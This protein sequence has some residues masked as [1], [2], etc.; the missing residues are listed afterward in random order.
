MI[1][2]IG[3]WTLLFLAI[4]TAIYALFWDRPG[5]RSRP[6]LRCRK[7]WYDLTESPGDLKASPIQCPECGKKHPTR[8]AMRKIR[9]S[10]KWILAA[11]VLWGV[12][13]GASVT[14]RVQSRGLGAAIP[15]AFIVASLPFLSEEQGTSES[16][17]T[18]W[19][20]PGVPKTSTK[21]DQIIYKEVPRFGYFP[22]TQTKKSEFGWFSR[23][24]AF[25]LARL[26]SKDILTDGTTAKGSAYQGILTTF[27]NANQAY[28]FESDWAK[29]IITIDIQ[30]DRP[31]GPQEPIYGILRVRRML[32]GS[33]RLS[34]GP[35]S[36]VYNCSTSRGMRGNGMVPAFDTVQ[37]R[38]EF[39]IKRFLWDSMNL[40]DM[41]YG[42]SSPS[43]QHP[44]GT[45][46]VTTN[47]T[48]ALDL[49]IRVAKYTG[50]KPNGYKDDTNWTYDFTHNESVNYE[51]D[52]ARTI[53]ADS[54]KTLREEIEN[55]TTANLTVE[56]D[57]GKERWIPVLKITI[58]NSN[59]PPADQD[60]VLFGGRIE[61]LEVPRNDP[62]T[63]GTQYFS[64]IWDSW[65]QWG[66]VPYTQTVLQPTGSQ[67]N[68]FKQ[69]TKTSAKM[70]FTASAGNAVA[71]PGE[72][73]FNSYPIYRTPMKDSILVVRLQYTRYPTN[74]AGFGGLWA[75]RVYEGTIQYP[76][77]DW[78]LKELR[79]YIV[80]GTVPDH[81]MP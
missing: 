61:I 19:M 32:A 60:T 43:Q 51:I 15:R 2:T 45:G 69:T 63:H 18:F 46:Q 39:W 70:R 17:G 1:W 26:E 80:N 13:Y 62:T 41:T 72:L 55:S 7:C 35:N 40:K 54:S 47:D 48:G 71:L 50:E 49:H 14:P 73:R 52:Q 30:I 59:K 81:S 74:N 24:I 37:E 9:R 44:L 76:L 28:K 4:A 16:M 21:F 38:R 3:Y 12:A 57:R 64:S 75:D 42:R 25:L 11:L 23:R 8:R 79:R 56:Y 58:I 78:T 20:S 68:P 53:V 66:A 22:G 33:Y 27:T 31:F 6:K 36:N 5:F 34:F 77:N 29:K 10:K 67:K 65:W